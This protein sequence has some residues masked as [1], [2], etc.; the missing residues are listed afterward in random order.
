MSKR[1]LDTRILKRLQAKAPTKLG[2]IRPALSDIRSKFPGITL[3]AAAQIYAK[4]HNFTVM[5]YLTDEDRLSL[6]GAD[7]GGAV[8]LRPL[9]RRKVSGHKPRTL[10]EYACGDRDLTAHVAEINRAY[11]ARCYT[12]CFILCR[13]VLENLVFHRVIRPKFGQDRALFSAMCFQPSTNRMVGF[14][15]LL[16]NLLERAG[17]FGADKSLVSRICNRALLFKD[18]ANEYAHSLY[19]LAKA[20]ELERIDVQGI[21]NHIRKLD[22]L[23]SR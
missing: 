2:S 10:I 14:E 3:N 12:A 23:L 11:D 20:G 16:K 17:D 9:Q 5:R 22:E 13:K 7:S 15:Q 8:P 18:T 19:H 4:R 21:L 1:L 6:R